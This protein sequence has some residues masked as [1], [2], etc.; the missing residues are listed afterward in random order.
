METN[1][2]YADRA[3][4]RSIVS[5]LEGHALRTTALGVLEDSTALRARVGLGTSRTIRH[6]VLAVD[7]R[8]LRRRDLNLIDGH[9][10]IIVTGNRRTA[11]EITSDALALEPALAQKITLAEPG[12]V[13]A[14]EARE[15]IGAIA[16]ERTSR[17]AAPIVA[18]LLGGRAVIVGIART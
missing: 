14:C 8:I 3:P 18:A 1:R 5:W 6:A 16:V 4:R 15:R 7:I 9:A 13:A 11:V 2:V 10:L 17:K 12:V